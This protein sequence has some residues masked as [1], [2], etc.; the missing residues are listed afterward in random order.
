[1]AGLKKIKTYQYDKDGKRLKVFNSM[2][3][4][5]DK[6]Y[7]GAKYPMFKSIKDPT[8]HKLP[9][10]T[11]LFKSPT[12]RN[13]IKNKI[14]RFNNN[15]IVG[16]NKHK[17]IEVI[18]IDG[19]KVAEFYNESMA[20]KLMSISRNKIASYLRGKKTRTASNELGIYI[21]YKN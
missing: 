15:L 21:R 18:N 11:F 12:Y 8:M 1:M 4:V 9:D 17:P 2:Q 7:K 5:R 13:E 6:Y 14:R 16:E 19:V 10:G 3:E 20:S